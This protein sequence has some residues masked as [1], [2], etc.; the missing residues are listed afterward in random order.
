MLAQSWRA[1]TESTSVELQTAAQ[2]M[3]ISGKI[4]MHSFMIVLLPGKHA[5]QNAA[6]LQPA[7]VQHMGAL[8]KHEL[9]SAT[10]LGIDCAR[11]VIGPFDAQPAW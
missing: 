11:F 1:P 10:R 4:L 5:S 7:G 3:T 6:Q 9:A 8:R 2:E